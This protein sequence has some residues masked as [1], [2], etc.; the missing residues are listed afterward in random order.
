MDYSELIFDKEKFSLLNGECNLIIDDKKRLPDFVFQHQFKKYFAIEYSCIYGE[1]FGEFLFKMATIFEDER[2]NYMTLDPHPDEW[3]RHKSSLFGLVSFEPSS[4]L[5]K[6]SPIMYMDRTAP[7]FLVSANIG[8]F[9]GASMKWGIFCDRISWEMAVIAVPDNVDV[10]GISG[11]RCMDA[12]WLLDYME[13]Q[14]RSKDK[15]IGTDFTGKFLDN[16]II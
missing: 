12:A 13:D 14:Y 1:E 11:F 4:L 2:V 3:D 15:N 8:V 10:P 16:Y 7:R 5:E 9:W 6:Y